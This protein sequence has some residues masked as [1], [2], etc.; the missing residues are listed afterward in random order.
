MASFQELILENPQE[1][2]FEGVDLSRVS[3]LRTDVSQV[4]FV[5]CTWPQNPELTLWPLTNVFPFLKWFTT[6]RAAIH[7]ELALGAPDNNLPGWQRRYYHSRIVASAT[8]NNDLKSRQEKQHLVADLYRQLRLNFEGTKQEV[9][10]GDFYIGQM[11]M[12]RQDTAFPR[13]YRLLLAAYRVLAMYGQ[14]YAR[15]FFW[16]AFI[17]APLFALGYTFL[18]DLPYAEGLFTALTAGALFNQLP[19][20]I[21]AWEKLLVYF[22]MLADFLLLGL[23]LV[24]TRRHFTR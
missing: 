15:P 5:G 19:D 4:R 1:V 10:A 21:E 3:F 22:N 7:D 12:R 13:P 17:L 2:R 23:I 18:S 11:E 20:G 9:E 8:P 24:A 6:K 14:S 16:Y